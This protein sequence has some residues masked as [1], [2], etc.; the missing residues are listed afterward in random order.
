V[1]YVT[2]P[3]DSRDQQTAEIARLLANDEGF[4]EEFRSAPL[5]VLA[6]FG[7]DH[8]VLNELVAPL[9]QE[10]SSMPQLDQ[11]LRRAALF[12]ALAAEVEPTNLEE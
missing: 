10:L 4:R 5:E 7:L 3:A 12:S 8:D 6:R 9:D 11:R 1:F 2:V